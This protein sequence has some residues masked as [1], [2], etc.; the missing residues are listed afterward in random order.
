[1][2]KDVR[3]DIAAAIASGALP[4]ICTRVT[5]RRFSLGQ[6]ID[7]EVTAVPAE[8]VIPNAERVR[9]E[10]EHPHDHTT[11]PLRSPDGARVLAHLEGLLG[12]YNRV[13]STS[14]ASFHGSATFD[15]EIVSAQ[16]AAIL[17]SS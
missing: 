14:N 17:A 12:V 7:I 3:A 13:R 11:L 9:F 5:V 10:A 6:S 8:L 15:H 2:A 4:A 16:R 1:V